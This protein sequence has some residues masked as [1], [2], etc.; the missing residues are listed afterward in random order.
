M[1]EV[2]KHFKKYY[3]FGLGGWNQNSDKWVRPRI[4]FCTEPFRFSSTPFSKNTFKIPIVLPENLRARSPTGIASRRATR[5]RL[6]ALRGIPQSYAGP[7]FATAPNAHLA[8]VRLAGGAFCGHE[9][10]L[11]H[12]QT[13]WRSR[14]AIKKYLVWTVLSCKI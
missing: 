9:D 6:R 1:P 8:P 7:R 13:P 12:V 10:H 4:E 11:G 5:L 2:K 3:A 14:E